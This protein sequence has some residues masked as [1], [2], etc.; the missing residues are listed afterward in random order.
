ME[1]D[2]L[3]IAMYQGGCSQ[4]DIAK[5]LT[6]YLIKNLTKGSCKNEKV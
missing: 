2:K 1:E 5:T 6:H 3:I 4:R